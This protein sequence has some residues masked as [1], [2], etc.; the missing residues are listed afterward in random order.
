MDAGALARAMKLTLRNWWKYA[1]IGVGGTILGVFLGIAV[2]IFVVTYDLPDY[3][4]LAHYEPP[5]TSR[6]YAA[7]GTLIGE[8]A[9]E[10]RLYMPIGSIP[11][12]VR[13]AFLSA[14]DKNFYRHPG[15]DLSGIIRAIIN[16]I[17]NAGTNR[18][19]EGASTITQQVAKN[20]LLSG[21]VS[22][23]RKIREAVLAMRIDDAFSKNQILELY[24]N[25]IFLG[26]N[27]YGVAS[28]ALNYFGK[29]LDEL[30]VAETA[31]LAALPKAPSYYHP[32]LHKTAAI[33]R[34]NWVIDQMADNGYI[35]PEQAEAAKAEDLVT[36][37]RAFGA[38]TQDVDYFVEEVR[39][40]LY[41]RYGERALYDGGLQVHSTLVTRLQEI[42]V[43]SLRAGLIAYDH[44]HGWRGAQV[45]VDLAGDW[46]AAFAAMRNQSG[47]KTWQLAV[48]TGISGN[49]TEIA[50]QDGTTGQIPFS[51]LAW[52][53]QE[54]R[55]WTG[56]AVSKPSDVVHPGDVVYVEKRADG[57][58]FSLR[59]VP[60]VNGAI[61]VMN[62]HTGQVLAMS[63][64]FSFG[65][66]VFNRA[67]QAMRQ[68]GSTFK[69]FVYAT[70]LDNGYTP[71]TKVLD[72]P[73]SAPMGGGRG[74][75]SPE[76][77]NQKFYGPLTLRRGIELSRNVMTVRLAYHV[78]MERVSETAERMGVY[79]HLPRYLAMAL[80][81]GE[82]TLMKLTTGYAEFVNGGRRVLPSVIDRIQDRHGYTIY[83]HDARVCEGCNDP[84]W[85]GQEEPLLAEERPQVLDPRTAYQIVSLL[86]GVVQRGTAT[87]VKAVGK[88][89]AGKTGTSNDEKDTWFVGFSP[90]LAVGVFVGFDN[91][92]DLGRGEAGGHTAA[93][94]FRDFMK[95]ALDG[96]PATPFRIPQG[97]IL[98]PINAKSGEPSS[99]GAGGAILEAFKPGTEPGSDTDI[100]GED[101]GAARSIEVTNR[102]DTVNVEVGNGTGGLY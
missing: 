64:G 40:V 44:R 91:P 93:P 68:V 13:G 26:Q 59:Q 10:R 80:G 50:L 56:P 25:Q 65:S 53:R 63:G 58:G 70:A 62:P 24:L 1:L 54:I 83:K 77:Y 17:S 71:I 86:E 79:P 46:R 29:S 99:L 2:Y 14:E 102:P 47:V 16:N 57:G 94:V 12:L 9:R 6:V 39:R 74:M 21:E 30:D 22:I 61:V 72:A 92:R 18:R 81:A 27:S 35:T 52:A 97:V 43:R 51:E 38:Q 15:I 84:S 20:F 67:T 98:M 45:K 19:P 3:Q 60:E 28:A 4:A 82:T 37:T 8:Y 55:T 34:R 85:R 69:P 88:P 90:D 100:F 5:V 95:A 101:T 49:T 73:F 36:R 75:W 89:L 7:D 96:Q 31:Y 42:A 66:S 32:V 11:A 33:A 48:V 87:V 23:S 76:N 41:D 78:G